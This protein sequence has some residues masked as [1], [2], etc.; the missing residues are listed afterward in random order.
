MKINDRTD[1]PAIV[2]TG[3]TLDG[4]FFAV[5]FSE[6]HPTLCEDFHREGPVIPTYFVFHAGKSYFKRI[7]N[8]RDK[9]DLP[10]LEN[11]IDSEVG[12]VVADAGFK[13]NRMF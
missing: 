10:D 6:A 7:L 11:F 3:E 8:S 1:L 4:T 2:K 12:T 9:L 13:V 5:T